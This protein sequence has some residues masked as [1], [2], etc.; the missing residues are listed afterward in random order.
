MEEVCGKLQADIPQCMYDSRIDEMVR[1]FE[2]RLRSQG[3]DLKTYLQYA[4]MDL[5]AF[6]KTFADQA[7]NQVETRLALEK[8]VELEKITPSQEEL[9]EEYGKIAKQYGMEAD[10][11]KEI[12]PAKEITMNLAMGKA[13]DLVRDSAVITEIPEELKPQEKESSEGKAE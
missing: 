12:L 10:K 9:D 5:E 7:K 1:E 3:M 2:Y 11:V 4:G 8:I 6:R 13:L